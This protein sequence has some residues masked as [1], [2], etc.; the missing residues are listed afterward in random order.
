MRRLSGD[1]RVPE[2]AVD[3]W[4]VTQTKIVLTLN[5]GFSQSTLLSPAQA[6][7]IPP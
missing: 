7:K 4:I 1:N 2:L 3:I 6:D 5:I